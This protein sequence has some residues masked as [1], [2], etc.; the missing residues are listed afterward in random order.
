[1]F[2]MTLSKA[3]DSYLAYLAGILSLIFHEKPE[4][5]MSTEKIS[6]AEALQFN[7][8]DELVVRHAR[9]CK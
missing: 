2:E 4:T 3:V 1:M 7:T 6:I 5:L 8:R 9:I